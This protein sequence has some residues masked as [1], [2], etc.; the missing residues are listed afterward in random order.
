[1]PGFGNDARI[2]F[3]AFF[4]SVVPFAVLCARCVFYDFADIDVSRWQ[5]PFFY[6]FKSARGTSIDRL[7]A[8]RTS[9]RFFRFDI[10]MSA[11][12]RVIIPLRRAARTALIYRVT[13][14]GT[15]RADDLAH[16]VLMSRPGDEIFPFRRAAT[17][18]YIDCITL[19][20]TRRCYGLAYDVMVVDCEVIRCALTHA[21]GQYNRMVALVADPCPL[22]IRF[23]VQRC[24]PIIA[25]PCKVNAVIDVRLH[26]SSREFGG[27][28]QHPQFRRFIILLVHG[29]KII[30]SV[31]LFTRNRATVAAR[32]PFAV[33]IAI[34][35]R[36]LSPGI[37]RRYGETLLGNRAKFRTFANKFGSGIIK[38]DPLSEAV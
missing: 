27:I 7:A 37:P 25:V 15:R 18:A 26:E 33:F 10:V 32:L 21:V 34:V 11:R 4:T 17:T 36:R 28:E 20:R 24:C 9:G 16:L 35:Q 14:F 30:S 31:L 38:R 1:M 13:L 19:F 2:L 12:L 5:I 22:V 3:A 29:V 23:S 8:L 6:I